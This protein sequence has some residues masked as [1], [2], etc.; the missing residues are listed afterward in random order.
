MPCAVKRLRFHLVIT[1]PESDRSMMAKADHILPYLL[2]HILLKS[3]IKL[4]ACA[5]KHEILPHKESEF[6]T[7]VVK[8]II[9]IISSSPDSYAVMIG[10]DGIFKKISCPLC[11]DTVKQTVLGDIIRSHCK[12]LYAV[13]FMRKTPAV[14]II[15]RIDCQGP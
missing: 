2:R 9:R 6:I 11:T 4:I 14:F 5:G 7:A 3:I 8:I 10:P 1:A 12:Y 15:I 13:Y